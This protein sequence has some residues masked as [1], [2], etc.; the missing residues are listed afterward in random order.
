MHILDGQ[1]QAHLVSNVGYLA[2][3][4]L[5]GQVLTRCHVRGLQAMWDEHLEED[6]LQ[7]LEAPQVAFLVLGP[8]VKP[9]PRQ[10]EVLG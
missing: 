9:R 6:C 5:D 7:V 8:L 1:A 3:L 10:H 2:C 4:L